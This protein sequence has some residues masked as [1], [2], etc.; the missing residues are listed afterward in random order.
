MRSDLR[1]A[2]RTLGQH[3]AFAATAIVTLALGIGASTAIFSVTDAVLLRPLPYRDAD[4]LVLAD[5][6]F[7]NPDVFDLRDGTRDEFDDVSGLVVFRA[8][9]PREDGTAER[10]GKA[11]VAASFFR[12]MGARIA[13]GRDFTSDDGRARATGPRPAFPLPE[14]EVAIL[15]YEYWQRRYG[16]D[17]AAIGREMP[18]SGGRGPRIIG[19]LEPGFRLLLPAGV[20]AEPGPD[21]WIPYNLGYD[22]AHRGELLLRVIARLKPGVPLG[23]AQQAADR[24]A[25]RLR[26]AYYGPTGFGIHLDPMRKPLVEEV[27]PAILALMGAVVFLLL[28]ACAN[29][30]NLVLVRAS[31]RER[32]LAMRAALGGSRWRLLRQMLTEALLL[33]GVATLAGVA[34]AAAGIRALVA[35]APAELPRLDA[36]ALDGRVLAFAGA[37]GLATAALAGVLPAW[38]A[39]MPDVMRVLGSGRAS[40][41]AT[42]RL[43]RNGVVVTA[44]AL[45]FVLL[46][47][48]GLM[49]RS[50][51]ELHRIDPGYD[52]HGLLT[53]LLV[54][55]ARSV[56][57]ERR[58]VLLGEIQERLRALP[59]VRSVA[60]SA[61]FPLTGSAPPIA[62]GTENALADA[63]Y[64]LPGY[65][66]TLR[67]RLVA[68]RTFTADDNAPT[69]RVAVIDRSLAARAFPN[70][71][72]VG[73]RL[74]IRIPEPV[75]V[76]VIG[77]VAHQRQGSLAVAGQEQI[78]FTDAFMGMGISRHWALR[79]GRDPVRCAAA[80]RAAIA[81]LAPGVFALTEVQT[82]D[83]LMDR[84]RA[85]T[86]FTLLLI[87]AFAALAALAAGVGL[88]GVL[89]T[90]VRQRTA[91]I[92]VRMAL[93]AA[94]AGVFRL[95]VGQGLL[96]SA[97]GIAAGMAAALGLT[98]AIAGLLVG[99]TPSDPSTYAAM[100]VVLL[101]VAAVACWLP[102]RRAAGLDPAAAL[103]EE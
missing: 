63:Q 80:A 54:G 48:S 75:A 28:I 103:R 47:G 20:T 37:A 5:G 38:R 1:Y 71:S 22:G 66:E 36:V 91:E 8:I 7:S 59:G 30:A 25:A 14:A 13:Y 32:E 50:F 69:R 81:R 95:V 68:G 90:V 29:V 87:G 56:P 18:A 73:E 76:E 67:T 92:G 16:G 15:S 79:T 4:R 86:R 46:V 58:L 85:G 9:V 12:M 43:V 55:D 6:V 70:R 89:S 27:R 84:A 34:L 40:A 11:Q 78:Y 17:P 60:A 62:W 21:V 100:A 82:M 3:P 74:L 24:V 88:Y 49:F 61:F 98:R 72:A 19:V 99:V 94:P 101:L 26:T 39:A 96:L 77:V 41:R 65:F 51:R 31:F 33:A 83:A 44:V 2:C 64:V 52:P 93:G 42:G 23:R 102:A 45:S 57:P 53:F 35:L 97:A 10:I